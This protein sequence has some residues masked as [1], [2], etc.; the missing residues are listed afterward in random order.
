MGSNL[1][2]MGNYVFLPID[3]RVKNGYTVSCKKHSVFLTRKVNMISTQTRIKIKCSEITRRALDGKNQSAFARSLGIPASRQMVWGWKEGIQA[4]SPMTLKRV[5]E[6]P[7][8]S[9]PAREWAVDCL[10]AIRDELTIYSRPNPDVTVAEALAA[11][12]GA[13]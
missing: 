3:N 11:G 1:S 9:Q 8:A 5:I 7:K 6:S 2:F 4:P 10:N 12:E 13:E